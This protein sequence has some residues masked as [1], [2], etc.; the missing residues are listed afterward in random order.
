MPSD[1]PNSRRPDPDD[2]PSRTVQIP[3]D[4]WLIT[5]GMPR[6]IVEMARAPLTGRSCYDAVRRAV[7]TDAPTVYL[8]GTNGNGKTHMASWLLSRWHL[9]A[10]QAYQGD[11][12]ARFSGWQPT[13]RWATCGDI[14]SALK[15]FSKGNFDYDREMRAFSRPDVLMI[16]DLWADRATEYDVASIVELVEARRNHNLRTIITG[17]HGARDLIDISRRFA[18]RLA[19]G[20]VIEFDGKSHRIATRRAN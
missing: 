15:N 16:D 2:E 9:T 3:W 19:E 7:N 4:S 6:R 10:M 18:D 5:C 1:S 11:S 20:L 17:N 8:W 13:A 14:T 12:D